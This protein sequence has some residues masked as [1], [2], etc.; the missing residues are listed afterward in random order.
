MSKDI[1]LEQAHEVCNR[2][3]TEIERV[4][5]SA[6]VLIHVEPCRDECGQCSVTC[7]LRKMK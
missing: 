7:S 1:K 6:N 4:L 3:E 5:L 2:I